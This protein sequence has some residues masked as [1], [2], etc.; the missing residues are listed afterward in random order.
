MSDP[1]D[2]EG[3]GAIHTF[4]KYFLCIY[5]QVEIS[6]IDHIFIDIMALNDLYEFSNNPQGNVWMSPRVL[7]LMRNSDLY[8]NTA[9]VERSWMHEKETSKP[10]P[11]AKLW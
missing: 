1:G 6:Q 3:F 7:D 11:A 2:F 8:A 10:F 4:D 9:I 5:P